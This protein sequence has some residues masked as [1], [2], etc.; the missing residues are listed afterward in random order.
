MSPMRWRRCAVVVTLACGCWHPIPWS[1]EGQRLADERGGRLR[2]PAPVHPSLADEAA[3]PP[4][5]APPPDAR[6][7]PP[8]PRVRGDANQ[9]RAAVGGA[10]LLWFRLRRGAGAF[11]PRPEGAGAARRLLQ[12]PLHPRRVVQPR[13]DDGGVLVE[14]GRPPGRLDRE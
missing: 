2:A 12:D 3:P 10:G 4:D 11:D 14:R 6:A 5:E 7:P 8:T 9:A 13:R 1:P